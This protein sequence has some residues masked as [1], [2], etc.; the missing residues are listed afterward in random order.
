MLT[1]KSI[2]GEV[3]EKGSKFIYVHK[4]DLGYN[5]NDE[6]MCKDCNGLNI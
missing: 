1:L 6:T 4:K 3:K 2:F 5:K